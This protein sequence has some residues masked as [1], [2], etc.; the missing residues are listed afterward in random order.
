MGISGDLIKN[1][2]T[3]PNINYRDHIIL[4]YLDGIV[5]DGVWRIERKISP[6]YKYD[7]LYLYYRNRLLMHKEIRLHAV[8]CHVN[9]LGHVDFVKRVTEA[10]NKIKKMY[11]PR[12][13]MNEIIK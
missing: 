11:E 12:R 7:R 1:A 3:H 8:I 5:P 2:V 10:A 9:E 4:A 13:L 6:K